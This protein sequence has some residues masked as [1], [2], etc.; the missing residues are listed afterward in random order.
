MGRDGPREP[1]QRLPSRMDEAAMQR[2]SDGFR[3]FTQ[4][5]G[6]PVTFGTGT[7]GA[8]APEEPKPKAK[9]GKAK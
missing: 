4:R 5:K 6:L 3:R 2:R 7:E 1:A 8:L 9:R